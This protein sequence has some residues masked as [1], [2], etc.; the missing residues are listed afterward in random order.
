MRGIELEEILLIIT[1]NHTGYSAIVSITVCSR[2][3]IHI[4]LKFTSDR[5]DFLAEIYIM[6]SLVI[7]GPCRRVKKVENKLNNRSSVTI[8]WDVPNPGT[9]V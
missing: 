5:E 3:F 2:V 8:F 1:V 6:L 7:F 9:L 4:R